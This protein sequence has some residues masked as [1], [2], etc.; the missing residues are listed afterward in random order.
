MTMSLHRSLR[1]FGW[2]VVLLLLGRALSGC[3]MT[4]NASQF[5]T[6]FPR[7]TSTRYLT[8][9]EAISAMQN[10]SCKAIDNH[11]YNAPIGLSVGGDVRN[12]AEGVDQIVEN[13]GGN[14]Y[15]II[16]FGWTIVMEDGTTQL[17]LKF[18]SL[19][20]DESPPSSLI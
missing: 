19:L 8:N 10:G 7:A 20:C 13:Y 1:P 11:T 16:Y 17:G 3:M 2:C 15:R 5:Y 9:A 12:G 4:M 6:E 18:T 14:A